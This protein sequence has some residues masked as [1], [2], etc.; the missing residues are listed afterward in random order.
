MARIGQKTYS[1]AE[2]KTLLEA[3]EKQTRRAA[4]KADAAI[5]RISRLAFEPYY[6]YRESLLELEGV[7]VLIEDRMANA[8]ER[9]LAQ[10]ADY[11]AKLIA[12]LL[13]MKI[14]VILRVFPALEVAASLP[15][16]AQKVFLATLWEM[17]ETVAHIDRAQMSHLLDADARKRLLVAETILG[18]VAQRAP[19]LLEMAELQGRELLKK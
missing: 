6:E 4:K 3:L 16:G 14:D 15:M 10:L 12:N 2:I 13:R 19:R 9:A 7:I 8:D 5:D 1:A 18:D 11:H 17:K